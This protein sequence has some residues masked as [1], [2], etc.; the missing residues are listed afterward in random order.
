MKTNISR[1]IVSF[2]AFAFASISTPASASPWMLLSG[3]LSSN[4]MMLITTADL[5][6]VYNYDENG[7]RVSQSS[8]TF[9]SPGAV[10]GSGIYGCFDWTP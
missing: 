3:T 1:A 9:G 4:M 5:C 6:V 7:N 2:A 8:F 10:W